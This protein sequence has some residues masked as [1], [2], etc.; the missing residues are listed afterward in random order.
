MPGLKNMTSKRKHIKCENS[1]YCRLFFNKTLGSKIQYLYKRILY[2][3]FSGFVQDIYVNKLT[4][5]WFFFVNIN[6]ETSSE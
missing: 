5:T 3:N 1:K 2:K 6:V 4:V